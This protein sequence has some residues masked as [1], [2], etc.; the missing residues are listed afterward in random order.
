MKKSMPGKNEDKETYIV[1]ERSEEASGV[2]TLSLTLSSGGIPS[3]ISGQFVTVYFPMT[4]TPE[5][6]AYS[7]SSAPHEKVLS[8]TVKAMGE[9][10]NRLCALRLGENISASLPYGYFWSESDKSSLVLIAGGIG[11]TPLRSVIRHA[12]VQTP[13]RRI[14]LFYSVK[15]E[16]DI[17]FRK[18]FDRFEKEHGNFSVAYFITRGPHPSPPFLSGRMN[19]NSIVKS[20][21]SLTTTEFFLC[22]SV[23]FV[24]DLWRGLRASGVPEEAIYTEAFFT[25]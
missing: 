1:V 10:S 2:V 13:S 15:R 14:K 18:E 11:I 9:F 16:E 19:S 5:G 3:F 7:I 25:Q 17:I 6:K 8:I 24:G 4:G 22:G 20:L 12:L 21:G 23:P